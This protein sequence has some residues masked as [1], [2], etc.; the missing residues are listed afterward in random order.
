MEPLGLGRPQVTT[1]GVEVKHLTTKE[2]L[3]SDSIFLLGKDQEGRIW[4]GGNE[5]LDVVDP[6]SGR[7]R[8]FQQS[9][10]GT[11]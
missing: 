2:G 8:G 10:R 6:A 5:G 4:A 7:V 3:A 9:R 1:S 11:T